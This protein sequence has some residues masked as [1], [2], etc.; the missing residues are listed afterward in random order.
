MGQSG[1]GLK[2]NTQVVTSPAAKRPELRGCHRAAER[3]ENKDQ[4][5]S[6]RQGLLPVPEA[7]YSI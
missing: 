2:L 1:R 4:G 5:F 7:T 6:A 3:T